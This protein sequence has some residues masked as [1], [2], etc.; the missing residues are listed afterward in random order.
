LHYSLSRQRALDTMGPALLALM[1]VTGTQL[2][3]ALIWKSSFDGSPVLMALYLLNAVSVFA[4]SVFTFLRHLS[5]FR[6]SSPKAA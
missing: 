6:M 2:L 5:S 1:I 3:G 4:F